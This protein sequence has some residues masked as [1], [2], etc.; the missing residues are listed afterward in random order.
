[1]TGPD[2]WRLHDLRRTATTGIARLG[3]R[4]TPPI[5]R[6]IIPRG[7]SAGWQ[8][9]TTGSN[10]TRNV[11]TRW[12]LGPSLSRRSCI[13]R[14]R[15]GTS[16]RCEREPQRYGAEDHCLRLSLNGRST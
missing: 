4:Q 6:S 9:F 14:A 16:L 5:V 12:R 3:F 7:R 8:L 1:M 11:A 15:S 10:I 2:D 13:P